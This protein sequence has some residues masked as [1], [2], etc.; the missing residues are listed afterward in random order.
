[1]NYLRVFIVISS[2]SILMVLT[3]CV[4]VFP[5]KTMVFEGHVYEA[6]DTSKPVDS[7]VV[8]G[9]IQQVP[10]FP[11]YPNCE[12]ETLTTFDGYFLI[13][14]E[15]NDLSGSGITYDKEGYLSLDSCQTLSDGT[16][17]CFIEPL[18]T[19]FR[20]Y[21]CTYSEPLSYDSLS[22]SIAL[23]DRDTLMLYRAGSCQNP[24][25][26]I[27]YFFTSD[28][29]LAQQDHGVTISAPDNSMVNLRRLL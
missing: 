20:V 12:I 27:S 3:H 6:Y 4:E 26:E 5:D 19:F 22:L 24:F 11:S 15:V 23:E 16:L 2:F 14:M 7:V 18:P 1:M 8:R 13:S 9:C 25:G 17:A 21:S 29:N 10:I 28:E